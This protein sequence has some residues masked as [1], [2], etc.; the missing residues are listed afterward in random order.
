MIRRIFGVLL[1]LIG[2]IV[3]VVGGAAAF[4]LIGPDNTVQSGEQHLSSKGLAIASTPDLL[5]RHG[6]VLHV[7]VR[8][9][10][11]QPVFVGVARDFDVSSYL[12]GF[13]HTKLV[14][15]QYPIA[16]STQDEKG[17]AGPLAAPDTL[18]WWV[19]K[20]N[21]TGTQSIA[22][23]IEDGPYDVVVMNADGKTAP[24]V[25]VDLGIEIPKAFAS[26]LGVFAVGIVLLAL[27][28]L[29]VLFRRRPAKPQ[30]GEPAHLPHAQDNSQSPQA[31]YPPTQP[32]PVQ[33]PP[34]QGAPPARPPMP[35][36]PQHQ[37]QPVQGQPVQQPPHGQPQRP[38]GGGAIRRVIVGGLA[39]G[40]VSG[41]AAVPQAD[42]V[43]ALTRPAI[44]D[45]AAVAV[46]KH[47]NVVNNKANSTRDDKLIATVEGGNLVRESQAGYEIDR[48]AKDKPTGP[49]VYTNPV[50]GAPQSAAYP[51][52]FVSNSGISTNK[53]YRHLGVWERETAGSPWMITFAA[54][55]KTAV[56]L[57]DFT[58]LR[59]ATKA[60]DTRLAAAPQVAATSLATYL[61]GGAKS[62]RAAAFQPN[63][64]ITEMLAG[65][66][67]NRAAKAKKRGSTLS[68][69]DTFTAPE[70]SPA[71]V[72]KS[73]TAVVFVSLNH[74]YTLV[75]GVNWRYWWD[76]MPENAFS[77]KSVMYYNRLT[78]ETIHD[79]VLVI[80]PK[81]KGKIQVA[82]FESQ[83]VAAGGS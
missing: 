7:D 41:C 60:D 27:G 15:V 52:S 71:F 35:T 37:G 3:A 56:K 82:S 13:A 67:S 57:P 30:H 45:S 59:A 72:T 36:G 50:I 65:I 24:D 33:Y 58:G 4:W 77:P 78:S 53:A 73:G 43:T 38:A 81:G 28:I 54:G 47:Y 31:Q 79:A 61:T 74:E 16:L 1:A 12:K 68:I 21:G 14:Q 5:N 2:L 25:Q 80:P 26:A 40:L 64:D 42:S 34:A 18:D 23:P 51:M 17:T 39:F 32:A 62:P 11:N 6:P 8:S 20:A 70:Q 44:T 9:T 75:P 46:I 48:V 76:G 19:A 22:W 10:K 83:V 49:F 29:L 55:V 69:S 66:V 63:A